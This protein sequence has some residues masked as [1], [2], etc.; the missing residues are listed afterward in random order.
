MSDRQSSQEALFSFWHPQT[1]NGNGSPINLPRTTQMNLDTKPKEVRKRLVKPAPKTRENPKRIVKLG[2]QTRELSGD[3]IKTNHSRPKRLTSQ[4]SKNRCQS[5][6]ALCPQKH[7]DEGKET[8]SAL[9]SRSK[10]FRQLNHTW[11]LFLDPRRLKNCRK[12]ESI[13]KSKEDKPGQHTSSCYYVGSKRG[14]EET[15]VNPDFMN[16]PNNN[17]LAHQES[18]RSEEAMDTARG[19]NVAVQTSSPIFSS[20]S[21][22]E[23][24]KYLYRSLSMEFNPCILHS[25]IV[26]GLVKND[27][28][29]TR[30][31]SAPV[32]LLAKSWPPRVINEDELSAENCTSLDYQCILLKKNSS[33]MSEE[34]DLKESCPKISSSSRRCRLSSFTLSRATS[35]S[36]ES[37]QAPLRP[38][39]FNSEDKLPSNLLSLS[40]N[41]ITDTNFDY[42]SS[43]VQDFSVSMRNYSMVNVR[44]N[45]CPLEN[46]DRASTLIGSDFDA[47]GFMSG[48]EDGI[49][50]QS[51][52]VFDSWRS[53]TTAM[54]NTSKPLL[55]CMFVDSFP[56]VDGDQLNSR[57]YEQT[58]MNNDKA[59]SD[60]PLTIPNRNK[61]FTSLVKYD[62]SSPSLIQDFQSAAYQNKVLNQ[63]A[64][65]VSVSRIFL[66][67]DNDNDDTY[68]DDENNDDCYE[69]WSKDHQNSDSTSNSNLLLS[70]SYATLSMDPAPGP[71]NPDS[72]GEDRRYQYRPCKPKTNV[73][74]WSEPSSLERLDSD[75]N[76]HRPKTAFANKSKD[77]RPGRGLGRR[78]PSTFHI[79]SQSVPISPDSSACKIVS[80]FGTWGLGSKVISEDWD[81]DFDFD[82]FD[83][84]NLHGESTAEGQQKMLV[85]ESIQASQ[86]NVT[87]HAGQIREVCMLVADLKNL[88]G[89][90]EA[91][92]L[93]NGEF[94]P[95]WLQ[96]EGIIALAAPIDEAENTEDSIL[97]QQTCESSSKMCTGLSSFISINQ[98]QLSVGEY[99]LSSESGSCHHQ[100]DSRWQQGI[101]SKAKNGFLYANPSSTDTSELNATEKSNSSQI[102]SRNSTE[103]ARKLM[104]SMHQQRSSSDPLLQ[105]FT[106]GSTNKLPFD[107][108]SLKDLVNRA[109]ALS[110][111]LSQIVHAPGV[112]SLSSAAR[113]CESSPAFTQVFL[114]PGI[115][116]PHNSPESDIYR[117]KSNDAINTSP[118]QG[119]TRQKLMSI[120][121]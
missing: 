47:K 6:S 2:P 28:W 72:Y 80:K 4:K 16:N 45:Y 98:S 65:A 30:N 22:I 97:Q 13:I 118:L 9:S 39:S 64:L 88:R 40:V 43:V 117:A 42:C 91:Q 5:F 56:T 26:K 77:T 104:E 114:D 85:P 101:D 31:H 36:N 82:C 14:S 41:Q 17:L 71:N 75:G 112:S 32:L 44:E 92:G 84:E 73:F 21:R 8:S 12:S 33:I 69:D 59:S 48:D 68:D 116:S 111:A 96:A 94:E 46:V 7:D 95:L 60:I 81:G 103:V 10:D 15:P 20:G 58:I 78:C 54:T 34:R 29:W 99:D 27:K 107:T 121:S 67:Q 115:T 76:P 3:V 24:L 57:T 79:R 100:F 51:D 18:H 120:V 109:S 62:Q 66:P 1:P 11:R 108:T 25:N 105:N 35:L 52:T 38:Q 19:T 74:E 106:R 61:S 90:G 89:L 86:E 50:F 23:N 53:G 49:D 70:S 110:R 102:Q 113:I 55:E 37:D 63:G 87:G 83:S 119:S 93:L